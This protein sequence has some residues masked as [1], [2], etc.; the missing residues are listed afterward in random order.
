[1]ERVSLLVRF[2]VLTLLA[3]LA[4]GLGLSQLLSG[5]IRD[6]A[7]GDARRSAEVIAQAVIQPQLEPDDLS[8]GVARER[9]EA[10]E[11]AVAAGDRAVDEHRRIVRLLVWNR[12]REIVYADDPGLRGR[13]MVGGDASS[14]ELTE[15]L[16][17][18]V[19]AE[20]LSVAEAREH[21]GDGHL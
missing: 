16:E 20:L 9:A 4:L 5:T 10:L 11:R 6:R 14:H 13:Q 21:G 17:C 19:E 8:G 12:D 3:F 15:A 7:L 1:M 2:A 18:E